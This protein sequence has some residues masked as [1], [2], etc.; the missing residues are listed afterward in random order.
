MLSCVFFAYLLIVQL[1]LYIVVR[2][3]SGHS[4][5]NSL[6]RSVY[7]CRNTKLEIAQTFTRYIYTISFTQYISLLQQDVNIAFDVFGNM[8]KKEEDF[9]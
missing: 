1:Q 8:K 9:A 7:Q 6:R 4:T 2:H 3:T 5:Q